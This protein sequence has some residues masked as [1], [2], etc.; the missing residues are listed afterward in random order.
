MRARGM[1]PGG[2]EHVRVREPVRPEGARGCRPGGQPS[3]GSCPTTLRS[4][5]AFMEDS[6]SHTGAEGRRPEQGLAQ[7]R[8]SGQMSCGGRRPRGAA[9]QEE[10]AG[11]TRFWFWARWESAERGWSSRT[12]PMRQCPVDLGNVARGMWKAEEP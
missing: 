2:G 11:Q 9:R 7:S 12:P 10:E 1:L 3:D 6:G 8:A 4:P 5:P